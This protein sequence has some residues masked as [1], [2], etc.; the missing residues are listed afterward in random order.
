MAATVPIVRGCQ[1]VSYKRI[2][3][4]K[5]IPDLLPTDKCS[6]CYDLMLG[7]SSADLLSEEN[8]IILFQM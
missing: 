7:P 1:E 5:G 2:K 3:Q 4:I 8:D 6:E